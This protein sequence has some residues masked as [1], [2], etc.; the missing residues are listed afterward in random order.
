MPDT[1]VTTRRSLALKCAAGDFAGIVVGGKSRR[2][3]R[4]C[5]RSA[6]FDLPSV[7]QASGPRLCQVSPIYP[8]GERRS[9][10]RMREREW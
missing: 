6:Y 1:I 8:V 9:K 5:A 4:T 2:C 10:Q 7:S 3:G